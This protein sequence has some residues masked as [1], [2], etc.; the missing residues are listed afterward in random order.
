MGEAEREALSH[1]SLAKAQAGVAISIQLH[2]GLRPANLAG[3]RFGK[4]LI[5]A[6]RDD[7]ESIIEL[8]AEV[9]K[10][11]DPFGTVLAPEVTAVVRRYHDGIL[12]RFVGRAPTFVFDSGKGAPKLATTVAWLV[13]RTIKRRLGFR[14]VLHQFRHLD[15]KI[16][17]DEH[18][19]AHESVRELLGHKNMKTTTNFYA[20]FDRRR[21]VR[22]HAQVLRKIA[23]ENAAAPSPARKRRKARTSPHLKRGRRR[24]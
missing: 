24:G 7:R 9:V 19:G 16:L 17:L 13:Q 4:T 8:P 1:R 14:M 18:P 5:L 21:A 20:G 10:N 2:A 6:D 3:L 11:G 22:L 12:R 15:A 23:E